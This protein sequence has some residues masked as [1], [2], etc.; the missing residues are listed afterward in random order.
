MRTRWS[1]LALLFLVRVSMA[2]QFQAVAALSP[3]MM[4]AYGVGLADIGLLIGLYLAPGIVLAV[5]GG[6][7]GMRYGD[8]RVV[9]AGL[10]LMIAGA[11]IMTAGTSFEAQAGGRLLAGIGGVL[12]NV[13][14]SK[15]V[16][17]LFAGREIATAM[18]IFVNSW[19]VG[20]AASLLLLPPIA[21][22]GGLTLALGA[23]AGFALLALVLLAFVRVPRNA[24]PSPAPARERLGGTALLAVVVAGAVWGLYNAALGMV[25]G[26]G[27]AMLA[28]RGLSPAAA[29]ATTSVALWMV[30]VS[31][32]LGG[33]LADR[34]GRPDTVLGAG[35]LAFAAALVLAID[36][37]PAL[38]AF[39]TLGLAGGLAAGPIM[40]LPSAVLRAG[41]RAQGMGVFFAL[42][43]LLIVLAP[44]LA[45][46]AAQRHGSAGIAFVIGAVMLC[47][48]CPGLLL[49]RSLAARDPARL[50]RPSLPAG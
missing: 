30:A 11:L 47:A 42:F 13:L 24:A 50:R 6:A 7:I 48:C 35:L 4:T 2:F 40:S 9:A 20:I 49:F 45:G 15:M 17:D 39:A 46:D 36:H 14:M 16:T 19:P 23:V 27:P 33:L 37:G 1:M 43:Y 18:G 5:P 29:S 8:R 3:M 25:F 21:Q 34:T 26:F 38:V 22:A 10:V 32:P 12:L 44:I 28:E 31:V 41:V